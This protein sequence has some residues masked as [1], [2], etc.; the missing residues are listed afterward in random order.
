MRRPA[1]GLVLV[2]ALV[3]CSSTT[4][5]DPPDTAGRPSVGTSLEGGVGDAL[6]IRG[7]GE[8]EE[9]VV[10]VLGVTDPAEPPEFGDLSEGSHLVAVEVRL[11]NTGS[12][13]YND[14]GLNI[15]RLVDDAD[16]EHDPDLM[17]I[18]EFSDIDLDPG[19]EQAGEVSFAVADGQEPKTLQITLGS[20]FGPETAVWTL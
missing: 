9:L 2:A 18:G 6:R 13:P 10:T 3:A 11:T 7:I 5:D 4:T 12:A 17:S 1:S 20:G 19:D 15:F 14:S 8:G 16:Q